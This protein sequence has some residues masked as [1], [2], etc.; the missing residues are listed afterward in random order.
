[1]QNIGGGMYRIRSGYA[2][3]YVACGLLQCFGANVGRRG[4]SQKAPCDTY[5]M[6]R[7]T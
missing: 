5:P 2:T 3:G 6:Q 7:S 4:S 1:M